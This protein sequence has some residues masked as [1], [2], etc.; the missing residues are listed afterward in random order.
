IHL[1]NSEMKIPVV[2]TCFLMVCVLNV[3]AQSLWSIDSL[4]HS[5]RTR[6]AV[7]SIGVSAWSDSLRTKVKARFDL[8]SLNLTHH[9]DSLRN[10]DFPTKTLQ[11]KLD[12]LVAKKDALLK[13]VSDKKDGLLVK[14]RER[15]MAWRDKVR[16]KLGVAG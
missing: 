8:D 9:I 1:P 14:S 11:Q 6:L 15:V 3:G 13:E 5:I 7:D 4:D 12:S 10:L 2:I 16:E